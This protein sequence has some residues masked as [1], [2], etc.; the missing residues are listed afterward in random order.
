MKVDIE[1]L[2]WGAV[3]ARLRAQFLYK[4][5]S[6]DSAQKNRKSY[7]WNRSQN[8]TELKFSMWG[9]FYLRLKFESSICGFRDLLKYRRFCFSSF[10][11]VFHS[12]LA[13][14][15]LVHWKKIWSFFS[16]N[17]PLLQWWSWWHTIVSLAFLSWYL[18]IIT[19]GHSDALHG[20]QR[21]PRV[22]YAHPNTVE[23]VCFFWSNPVRKIFLPPHR[24]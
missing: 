5:L 20:N 3:N 24:I 23:S 12:I 1:R 14:F 15:F 13:Q 6:E 7:S 21:D 17:N 22:A 4:R 2:S 19:H 10:L 9:N 16:Y 11:L 18:I 8:F